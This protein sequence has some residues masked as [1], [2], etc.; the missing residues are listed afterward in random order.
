MQ[1]RN[2]AKRLQGPKKTK[3]KSSELEAT[4]EEDDELIFD[5]GEVA[6][7]N[8]DAGEAEDPLADETPAQKRHRIGVLTICLP[9][10]RQFNVLRIIL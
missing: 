8:E 7:N 5:G 2:K 9:P 10:E 6:R 1:G 4:F 3:R